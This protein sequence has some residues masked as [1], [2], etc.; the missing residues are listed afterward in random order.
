MRG[1]DQ[2]HRCIRREELGRVTVLLLLLKREGVVVT[3]PYG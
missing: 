3:V 1:S 2:V